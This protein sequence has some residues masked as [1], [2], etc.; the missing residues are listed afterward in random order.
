[1][2]RL[3]LQESIPFPYTSQPAPDEQLPLSSLAD[4]FAQRR[5]M[6]P[7]QRQS[8]PGPHA[9]LGLD[10]YT[11]ATSPL[12]RYADLVVHQQLRAYLSG[13]DLLTDQQVL[14][15]ISQAEAVS[16]STRQVERLSNKHW[17]LVYLQQ[18]PDWSGEGILVERRSGRDSRGLILIPE[19]D[20]EVTMNI[21]EHVALND[22]LPLILTGINLPLLDAYFRLGKA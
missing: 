13:Q 7:G 19:L 22:S 21:P 5:L 2:A 1:L 3:A 6:K 12:R 15:R 16:G 10:I 18:K 20:L 4:M 11:Q 9:G 8:E 17:T 14:D